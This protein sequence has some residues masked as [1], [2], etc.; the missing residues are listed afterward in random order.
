MHR[1]ICIQINALVFEVCFFY[2][3]WWSNA[4]HFSIFDIKF[5]ILLFLTYFGVLADL[6]TVPLKNDS[7]VLNITGRTCTFVGENDDIYNFNCWEHSPILASLT[8]LFI[9]MPSLNV[10]AT[11]YGPGTAGR[12]GEVWG[13]VMVIL[14]WIEYFV[15]HFSAGSWFF[16]FL[17]GTMLYLGFMMVDRRIRYLKDQNRNTKSLK[18]RIKSSLLTLLKFLPWTLLPPSLAIYS[19]HFHNHKNH[20]IG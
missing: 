17:G 8:L 12:V 11:L 7:S 10:L 1:R 16:A 20:G 18:E 4:R 3:L 2:Y 5:D 6:K 19:F 13:L 14:C 15:V 9:Y